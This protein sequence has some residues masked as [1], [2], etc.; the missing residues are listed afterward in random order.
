MKIMSNILSILT[1]IVEKEYTLYGKL[2]KRIPSQMYI[3]GVV[4][5]YN[6]FLKYEFLRRYFSRILLIDSELLTLKMDFFEGM[7][8]EFYW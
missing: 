3:K 6:S 1:N 4:Y 8:Q 5:I 7:F 2:K